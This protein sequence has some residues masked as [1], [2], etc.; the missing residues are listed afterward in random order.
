MAY[1]VTMKEGT[2][3]QIAQDVAR[4]LPLG[5]REDGKALRL[6]LGETFA[7]ATLSSKFGRAEDLGKV[8]VKTGAYHHQLYSGN[9]A[10]GF[11]RSRPHTEA[12][13]KWKVLQVFMSKIA[14]KIDMAIDEIDRRVRSRVQVCLL[15]APE[16]QLVAFWSADPNQLV[17][18]I[19]GSG[20]LVHLRPGTLIE[21]REFL[22]RLGKEVPV[23]GRI[24]YRAERR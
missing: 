17:Y 5:L 15:F 13:K 8:A 7:V 2:S 24:A 11:V 1:A 22:R 19:D 23:A 18:V 21:G 6:A 20:T 14:K 12:S 3:K 4:D 10:V 9:Q 16:Y